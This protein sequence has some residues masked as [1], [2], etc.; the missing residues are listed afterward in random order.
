MVRVDSVDVAKDAGAGFSH[1]STSA[2]IIVINK[3]RLFD[4]IGGT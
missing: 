1:Y 2:S 3:T 4:G